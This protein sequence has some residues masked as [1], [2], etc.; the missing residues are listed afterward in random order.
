MQNKIDVAP[1]S[2]SSS[3]DPA[4]LPRRSPLPGQL[5][6]PSQAWVSKTC[7]D[8]SVYLNTQRSVLAHQMKTLA[9]QWL[10][11][12]ETSQGQPWVCHPNSLCDPSW[13][14]GSTVDLGTT[15]QNWA[16]GEKLGKAWPPT[17]TYLIL[18]WP[19]LSPT[20]R[21][22]EK[23]SFHCQTSWRSWRNYS[24]IH[25]CKNTHHWRVSW[26]SKLKT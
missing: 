1:S 23:E 24:N 6:P 16:R 21:R 13:T 4:G 17:K 10:S 18:C 25:S 11:K 19:F 9:L 15:G 7:S 3:R 12:I 5:S 2:A 26:A 8:T 14:V 20:A 22:F